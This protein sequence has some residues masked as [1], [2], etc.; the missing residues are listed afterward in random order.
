MSL[1]RLWAGWRHDYINGMAR[2]DNAE[3]L[4]CALAASTDDKGDYIIWRSE[5]AF[6]ALNAY[7]YSSGHLMV[8]PIRHV[9][10]IEELNEGE[11]TALWDALQKSTVAIKAAYEPQ[12]LNIGI[13]LGRAAGAGVPDH[14]HI[15]VV[16][17]WNGDTNFMT[18]I[19]EARVLPEA[20]DVSAEKL[21]STWPK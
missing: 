19:A 10:E 2:D 8:S 7:P 13:N 6:V 1:E 14:L 16:P 17:R 11:S 21:R 12:G 18:S 9:A 4:M 5:N 15:H 3:C 20:L